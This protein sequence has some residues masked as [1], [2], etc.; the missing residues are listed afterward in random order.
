MSNSTSL[1]TQMTGSQASKEVTFNTVCDALSPS[2]FWGR[3]AVSSTGLSWAYFGG[4]VYANNTMLLS[5]IANGTV[6]LTASATNYVE[7]T[8]AGVVS[9]N[10][11]GF[12]AGRIPLYTVVTGVST[13][14]SWIDYRTIDSEKYGLIAVNCAGAA[15]ITLTAVQLRANVIQLTGVLTG[16]IDLLFPAFAGTYSIQN[17]TT[18]AFTITAKVSGGTGVIVTQA[19]VAVVITDGTNTKGIIS[20]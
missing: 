2:S 8:Q 19:K 14:T 16:S 10:T 12:T 17:D 3:N 18:G 1:L 7:M 11:T 6:T 13:V 15:N 5:A 4:F 20:A 9:A